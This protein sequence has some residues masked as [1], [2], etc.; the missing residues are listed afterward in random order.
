MNSKTVSLDIPCI[1]DS[2]NLGQVATSKKL[3]KGASFYVFLLR[4]SLV[5]FLILL[6]FLHRK[7]AVVF[8][9]EVVVHWFSQTKY[10][11]L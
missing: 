6:L 11:Q 2:L 8:V 4:S 3:T 5:R 10:L 9:D 1:N 7:W